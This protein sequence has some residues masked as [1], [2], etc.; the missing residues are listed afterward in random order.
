MLVGP[1]WLHVNKS[2]DEFHPPT[3]HVIEEGHGI[4]NF[5]LLFNYI[6]TNGTLTFVTWEFVVHHQTKLFYV[7]A[8]CMVSKSWNYWFIENASIWYCAMWTLLLHTCMTHDILL[9]VGHPTYVKLSQSKDTN[10]KEVENMLKISQN[11]CKLV[12]M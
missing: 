4:L 7:C 9:F 10:Y 11:L 5:W 1:S 12:E 6:I 2:M 8:M 3:C